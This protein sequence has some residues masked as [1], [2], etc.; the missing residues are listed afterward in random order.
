V[1]NNCKEKKNIKSNSNYLDRCLEAVA[2][3]GTAKY[4]T[5]AE[6]EGACPAN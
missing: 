4:L 3:A 1:I 2:V 5:R 6:G